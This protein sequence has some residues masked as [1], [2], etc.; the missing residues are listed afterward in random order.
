MKEKDVTGFTRCYKGTSKNTYPRRDAKKPTSPR[1]IG[2]VGFISVT[3]ML[4]VVS[5]IEE[6][7]GKGSLPY[8]PIN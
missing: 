8:G 6:W 5:Y 7:I 1:V 4:H 3:A 2:E